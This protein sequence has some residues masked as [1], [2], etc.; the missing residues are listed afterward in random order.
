[1]EDKIIGWDDLF[2][3]G[4]KTQI[5]EFEGGIEKLKEVYRQLVVY[6]DRQN[7]EVSASLGFL[8][9]YADGL[10]LSLQSV[11]PAMKE[12]QKAAQELASKT[13]DAYKEFR[14]GNEVLNENSIIIKNLRDEVA[15]LS[16][17]QDDFKNGIK[18]GNDALKDASKNYEGLNTAVEKNV[19]AGGEVSKSVK[20][21]VG[22]IADLKA[23]LKDAQKEYDNMEP[24]QRKLAGG[25]VVKR[26]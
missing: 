7:G 21:Q 16:K 19:K 20:L 14:K 2:K 22:S 23:Q 8:T 4:D 17:I 11:N 5:A 25:D 10:K 9:K 12:S 26:N 3:F 6:I 1:M 13:D 24:A 15:R 18:A